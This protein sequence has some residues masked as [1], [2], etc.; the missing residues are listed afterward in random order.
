MIP[1]QIF[2]RVVSFVSELEKPGTGFLVDHQDGLALV[3]AAHLSSGE[4]E[5]LV[6]FQQAWGDAAPVTGYLDRI[7]H[8]PVFD[9]AAYAV[10]HHLR[11]SWF[12][13]EVRLDSDRLIYG[14]DCYLLGYP[15]GLA[16]RIGLEGNR[17]PILRKG[18]IA[19]ARNE[20][21]QRGWYVDATALPGFSGGP[22]VYEVQ[23]TNREYAI[24]GVIRGTLVAP[25]AE[26][27]DE[28]PEPRKIPAG[29]S[30]CADSMHVLR[31][32]LKPLT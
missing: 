4:P 9:V 20:E 27:T 21:G 23:G 25:E 1:A 18:I 11:P 30:Q 15:Y 13:G 7:G 14:Q 10:P 24:A 19:G 6:T 32:G 31:L 2:C 16:T 5:E 28:N 12:V 17:L 3:T 22:L 26:P 29:I 8:D